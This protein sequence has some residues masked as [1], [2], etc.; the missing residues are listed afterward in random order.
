MSRLRFSSASF[1]CSS[2]DQYRV[3]QATVALASGACIVLSCRW[4]LCRVHL[5]TIWVVTFYTFSVRPTWTLY[6]CLACAIVP[7]EGCSTFF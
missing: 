2:A 3:F 1:A 7:C 4:C 5:L 6:L